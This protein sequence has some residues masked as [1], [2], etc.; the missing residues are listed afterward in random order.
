MRTLVGVLLGVAGVLIAGVAPDS[1]A[2]AAR[3]LKV[4]AFSGVPTIPIRVADAHGIFERHGLAVQ[5]EITPN[6]PQLRDGLAAGKYD[7]AHA[8]VDNAVAMVDVAGADVVVVLGGDD[9]MNELI[10]QPG[11]RSVA[12]L[13]GR[14]VI[15]DAPNTAYALQLRKI[16]ALHGVREG[17]YELKV[18]GGTPLRLKAMLADRSNA[19]TMLN[20]PFSIEAARQGLRPL[21]SAVELLGPYQGMG[22]F[23]R[24]EWARDNRDALVRYL[25]AFLEAQRWFVAPEHRE[26][27]IALLAAS[28]EL[29]AGVAVET[30]ERGLGG[31]A[32]DAKLNVEGFR[33]V[34]ALRAE[35]EGQWGGTPPS[36]ERYYDLTYYEAALANAGGTR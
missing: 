24:R 5:V 23:V 15:V 16:L 2:P 17:E 21:G 13:R 25:T 1:R 31:L 26:E 29:D 11:L 12:D 4:I 30:Y 19:A 7:I 14:T 33:R 9:S 28:L 34:L 32:P 8:A 3:S 35:V 36:P 18:V 20:P 27:A 6:S 22:A 10:V